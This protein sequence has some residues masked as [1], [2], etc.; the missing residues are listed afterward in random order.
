MLVPYRKL[1]EIFEESCGERKMFFD[2]IVLQNVLN[3]FPLLHRH[4][5]SYWRI[6]CVLDLGCPYGVL[7]KIVRETVSNIL[8]LNQILCKRSIWLFQVHVHE[9]HVHYNRK[10]LVMSHNFLVVSMQHFFIFEMVM[11]DIF[12]MTKSIFW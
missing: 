10:L 5:A 11:V 4:T 3:C 8:C 9:W 1:F 7:R 6:F 12:L 2:S